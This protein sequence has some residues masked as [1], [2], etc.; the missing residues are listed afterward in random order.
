DPEDNT[1]AESSKISQKIWL[2]YPKKVS[3]RI[4][5][6]GRQ[7]IIS[8]IDSVVSDKLNILLSDSTVLL[9]VFKIFTIDKQAQDSLVI[10][11]T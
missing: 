11:S 8:W 9:Q 10:R 4:Q 6:S 1:I 2:N 7:N 3:N 5:G